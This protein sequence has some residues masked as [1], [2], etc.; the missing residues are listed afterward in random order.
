VGTGK[1]GYDENDG[2]GVMVVRVS[3]SG[4]SRSQ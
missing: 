2:I 3:G 1:G 4:E